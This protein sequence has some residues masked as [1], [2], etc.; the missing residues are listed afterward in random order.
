MNEYKHIS[1]FFYL[2]QTWTL[3]VEPPGAGAFNGAIAGPPIA[4]GLSSLPQ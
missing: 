4:A 3:L 1:V 2:Q